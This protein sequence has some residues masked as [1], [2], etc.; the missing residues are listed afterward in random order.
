MFQGGEGEGRERESVR[1]EV[2]SSRHL[3]GYI[4]CPDLCYM[5]WRFELNM[6]R[7]VNRL[8]VC[9]FTSL[10][11]YLSLSMGDGRFFNELFVHG[12][13]IVLR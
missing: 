2:F 9:Q 13:E 11:V 8:S 3:F 6:V 10:C 5:H 1:F 7:R 12:T 4:T